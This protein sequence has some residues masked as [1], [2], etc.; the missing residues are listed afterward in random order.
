MKKVSVYNNKNPKKNKCIL[1][2][3]SDTKIEIKT[4]VDHHMTYLKS[5]HSEGQA[6]KALMKERKELIQVA[7]PHAL[8]YICLY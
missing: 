7:P 4:E 6:L 3:F 1:S 8:Y 2:L 5:I